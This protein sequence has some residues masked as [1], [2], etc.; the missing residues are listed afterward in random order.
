MRSPESEI[1]RNRVRVGWK[2]VCFRGR[3]MGSEEVLEW[4][5]LC[6]WTCG[7]DVDVERM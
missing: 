4:V 6:R 3:A 7:G 1:P 2:E 5:V